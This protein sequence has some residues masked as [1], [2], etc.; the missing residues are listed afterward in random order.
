MAGQQEPASVQRRHRGIHSCASPSTYA[1]SA[2]PSAALL[3]LG[4]VAEERGTDSAGIVTLHSGTLTAGPPAG[5]PADGDR[6]TGRWRILTIKAVSRL[7]S[8][9]GGCRR[10][11]RSTRGAGE[12]PPPHS[13]SSMVLSA[14]LLDSAPVSITWRRHMLAPSSQ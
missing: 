9:N 4:G 14:T 12:P 5:P 1:A 6:E 7:T 3:D 13:G 11:S 8:S 10:R 2:A